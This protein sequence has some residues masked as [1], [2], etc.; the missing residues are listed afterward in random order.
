MTLRR[1]LLLLAFVF[2]A[3][4]PR[5]AR[6]DVGAP[7]DVRARA[8]AAPTIDAVPGSGAAAAGDSRTP[9]VPSVDLALSVA[10]ATL[11]GDRVLDVSVNITT[12]AELRDA[13]LEVTV[14]PNFRAAPS[15]G[16]IAGGY[17]NPRR[18]RE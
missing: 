3:F 2:L 14:P 18:L 15:I 4:A 17:N 13:K 16:R 8:D 9:P 7:K 6:A 5:A 10:P 12:S 11:V 1:G